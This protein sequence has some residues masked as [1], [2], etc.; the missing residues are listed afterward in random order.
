MNFEKWV[1]LRYP[2]KELADLYGISYEELIDLLENVSNFD[3]EGL[4]QASVC[5]KEMLEKTT[6][7]R[8]VQGLTDV[9]FTKKNIPA[10]VCCGNYNLPD[11]EVFTAPEKFS[12]NGRIN[13]NIDG[14]FRGNVYKN[15]IVN[16]V[17]GKLFNLLVVIMKSLIKFLI[18]MLVQDILENLLLDLILILI[19][20][21]M[22][23]YSMKKWLKLFIL[24]LD[25]HIIKLIM[26]MKA[27]FIGTL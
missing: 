4:K 21:I 10:V 25:I 27:L 1:Y 13:F 6:K 2:Q 14:F 3:Y 19:E 5:L 18:Q 17:D 22:T 15:I 7:V 20:I 12:V 9:S 11:G 8:I 16:V 24:L 26:E 23:I